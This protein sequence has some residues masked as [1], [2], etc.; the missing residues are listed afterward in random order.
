MDYDCLTLSLKLNSGFKDENNK[1]EKHGRKEHT[2]VVYCVVCTQR[3][4]RRL[5]LHC[6]CQ[7][8]CIVCPLTQSPG[9][10]GEKKGLEKK[11][12]D[13]EGSVSDGY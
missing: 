7:P 5:A 12:A 2:H 8:T 6:V 13:T 11:A 1:K 9:A 3:L 10:A 4:S